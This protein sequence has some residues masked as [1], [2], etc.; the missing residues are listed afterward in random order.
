MIDHVEEFRPELQL[1]AFHDPE[2]LEYRRIDIHLVRRADDV[3]PGVAKS[4]ERRIG[5]GSLVKP[6]AGILVRGNQRYAG[7]YIGPRVASTA[8]T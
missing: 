3:A 5:K 1:F 6:V 2:V 8:G 7:H 4:A